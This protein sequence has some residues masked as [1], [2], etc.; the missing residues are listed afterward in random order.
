MRLKKGLFAIGFAV[1]LGLL[2][3][4]ANATLL[5]TGPVWADNGQTYQACNVVNVSNA[6]ITDLQIDLYK[7]DGTILKTSGVITLN[8]QHSVEI[9]AFGGYTGF[10]RCRIYSALAQP[11]Q[12]RGNVTTFRWTGTYYDSVAVEPAR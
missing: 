9:S 10:A 8:P 7:S 12:I 6:A 1:G 4:N 5:A 2:S 11:W 3:S